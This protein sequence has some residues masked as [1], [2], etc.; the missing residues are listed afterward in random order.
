MAC[1][2]S[3]PELAPWQRPLLS[4]RKGFRRDGRLGA[5]QG[6]WVNGCYVSNPA[7]ASDTAACTALEAQ[8]QL[9]EEIQAWQPEP[10]RDD[11]A[12]ATSYRWGRTSHT[13]GGGAVK[14]GPGWD[15]VSS[16]ASRFDAGEVELVIDGRR[17]FE[18][19]DG[20]VDADGAPCRITEP[21]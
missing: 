5:I 17:C 7:D 14:V 20:W 16:N 11:A 21:D 19:E 2:C 3:D 13:G 15:D 12:D 1:N 18:T 10:D 8:A 4:Q 6:A 9:E